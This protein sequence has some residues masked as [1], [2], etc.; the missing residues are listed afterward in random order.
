[1]K[2]NNATTYVNSVMTFNTSLN[3]ESYLPAERALLNRT[4]S[5]DQNM[6]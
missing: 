4:Y 6:F 2:E 5:S 3:S 1:M